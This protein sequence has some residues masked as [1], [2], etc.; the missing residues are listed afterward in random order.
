MGTQGTATLD[1]GAFPGV[2]DANVAV[3]GQGGIQASSL[4][5]AWILPA[6]TTDHSADEHILETFKV[7]ARDI[8]A[9]TG[10]TIYGVNTSQLNENPAD[11]MG[12]ATT[13]VAGQGGT[14]TSA[15]FQGTQNIGVGT[16]IY[17]KWNI[18]WVWN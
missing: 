4:V 9:G 17:G 15:G 12:I 16:R 6:A 1:F 5:E 3:T 14:L 11:R 13:V 8:V 7:F 18:A 10:F 2:S